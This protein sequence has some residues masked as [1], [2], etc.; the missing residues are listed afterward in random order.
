MNL[1]KKIF[2]KSKNDPDTEMIDFIIEKSKDYYNARDRLFSHK[3][4][5]KQYSEILTILIYKAKQLKEK[6]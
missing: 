4:Q 2:R 6:S 1:I 3:N 5:S